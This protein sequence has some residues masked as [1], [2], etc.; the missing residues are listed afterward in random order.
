MTQRRW[1]CREC[2]REWVEPKDCYANSYPVSITG[3][4][5]NSNCQICGSP[6]IELIEFKP[7]VPGLDLP[8]SEPTWSGI[9]F[10]EGESKSVWLGSREPIDFI[11]PALTIPH[12]IR[13]QYE[14][15]QVWKEKKVS[16]IPEFN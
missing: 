16:S 11:S 15:V 1:F 5:G 7:E 2:K 6:E 14:T 12:E 10:G 4:K 13:E 8:R 3:N 9:D